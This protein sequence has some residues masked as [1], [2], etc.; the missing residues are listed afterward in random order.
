MKNF[1]AK[2]FLMIYLLVNGA[3]VQMP[4]EKRDVFFYI[5]CSYY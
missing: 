2:G 4:P 5:I 3:C 1:A